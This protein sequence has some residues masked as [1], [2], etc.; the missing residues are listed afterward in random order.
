M[1]PDDNQELDLQLQ[2]SVQA[3]TQMKD[4]IKTDVFV[5]FCKDDVHDG[6]NEMTR[7]C[8]AQAIKYLEGRGFKWYIVVFMSLLFIL[9]ITLHMLFNNSVGGNA[10]ISTSGYL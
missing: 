8:P 7:P 1:P 2:R 3:L 6:K 10:C 5:L 4:S 9:D